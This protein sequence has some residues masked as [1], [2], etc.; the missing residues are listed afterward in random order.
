MSDP[1]LRVYENLTRALP[2]AADASQ[3][4]RQA[5]FHAAHPV[6]GDS[7]STPAE[8]EEL[9]G[10]QQRAHALHGDIIRCINTRQMPRRQANK[11]RRQTTHNAVLY[12]PYGQSVMEVQQLDGN[13]MKV[14]VGATYRNK[15]TGERLK[16]VK[17]EPPTGKEVNAMFTTHDCV[18]VW[19]DIS[20]NFYIEWDR[21]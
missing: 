16:L 8:I 3:K 21:V 1:V 10:L 13:T 2:A 11:L 4:L 17:V 9:Q 5:L 12:A 15:R 14:F 19:K 7:D 20:W 6:A 18:E